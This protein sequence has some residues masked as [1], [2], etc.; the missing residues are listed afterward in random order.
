[1]AIV[2]EQ[3][4][5]DEAGQ[6]EGHAEAGRPDHAPSEAAALALADENTMAALAELLN[7][8]D[9]RSD[10]VR[11]AATKA[12]S[13]LSGTAEGREVLMGAKSD[14]IEKLVPMMEDKD[15]AIS[16]HAV[17][18]V[19][20]LCEYEEAARG[21]VIRAGAMP[22]VMERVAGG[23]ERREAGK[24][25]AHTAKLLANLTRHHDGR[26][27]AVGHMSDGTQEQRASQLR[28]LAD[29]FSQGSGAQGDA[30]GP[31]AL[32]FENIAGAPGG[33]A[34]LCSE[35]H[36][37]L[38]LPVARQI[39]SS[40]E[41]RQMGAAAAIKNCSFERTTHDLMAQHPEIAALL[42]LP[43]VG[44]RETF[45]DD[46]LLEMPS[47]LARKCRLGGKI[48][49][50]RDLRFTIYEAFLLMCRSREGREYLRSN[51]IYPV[52]REAHKFEESFEK[53]DEQLIEAIE[54]IVDK[55]MLLDE[56]NNQVE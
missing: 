1:M 34:L 30:L 16:T 23:F 46:D 2:E 11:E 20:N 44:D 6:T 9:T 15:V 41:E 21:V 29:A 26:I 28:R 31:L 42:C 5:H 54:L 35:A 43:I 19:V 55:V 33:P 4:E 24:G 56:P 52:L 48:T 27:A 3:G 14:P 12:A 10:K 49:E 51:K 7:M 53:P 25:L 37:F 39:A 17:A 8:L 36:G 32:F 38:L 22:K 45:D 13:G 47:G 40:S 18:A 50:N